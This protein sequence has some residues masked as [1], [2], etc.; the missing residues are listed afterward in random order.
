MTRIFRNTLATFFS[1]VLSARVLAA[2]ENNAPQTI[3]SPPKNATLV[4]VGT[5]TGTPARSKGI[6]L[7]WLQTNGDKVSK[8]PT[9][10]PLGVAAETESPSFLT[11]DTKRHLLFCANET[12]SF[13]G[14]PGGGVSAFSIDPATGKLM[15]IN[16]RS[17]MGKGPCHVVLDKTGRNLLVANYQ[18]GNVAIFPVSADGHLGEATCLFQDTGKG[19]NPA[20]QEGPHAHCV[21]LSPDNRFAFVCDL[22]TDKVMVFRFDAGHGRLTPNDPP[23]VSVKPGAGPRHLVFHPNGKFAY[24][25]NEIDSTLSAFAYDAKTGALKELQTVSSL[26]EDYKGF[27]KA[28]EIAIVPSGKFL[29]A[30]NRGNDTVM[31]FAIDSKKGTL[32][33]VAEQS[34]GGKTPRH[35]GITPS[36]AQVVI[37]N[38]DSNTALVCTIDPRSG[39]LTPSSVLT[40]IPSPVCAVFLPAGNKSSTGP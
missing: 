32:S 19:P 40:N 39:R 15:L 6:Y 1:L 24:L 30:S 23:F 35:F 25:V 31:T 37:C 2:T 20:R 9:F 17:S 27:N 36:G 26:P 33:R 29:F 38:Q 5:F 28:A 3:D 16:Q 7:F 14:E 8:N 22:G 10:V 4:Y 11:L 13:H 34:T 21:A 18:S 12:D